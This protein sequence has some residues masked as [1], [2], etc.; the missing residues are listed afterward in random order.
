MEKQEY[1]R[2]IHAYKNWY[3]PGEIYR[4]KSKERYAQIGIQVY[5]GPENIVQPD[6]IKWDDFE[7]IPEEAAVKK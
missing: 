5:R 2:V 3:H 7:Y 1:V 4:V 6:V